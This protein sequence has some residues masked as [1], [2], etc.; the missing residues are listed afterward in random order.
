M[1]DTQISLCSPIYDVTKSKRISFSKY[2]YDLLPKSRTF[3]SRWN[4]SS[5]LLEKLHIG[6]KSL[7]ENN[8]TQSKS[9][10]NKKYGQNIAKSRNI[11]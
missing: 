4:L 7:M 9:T 10:R 11:G 5:I 2:L 6:E 8:I 1:E 3:D